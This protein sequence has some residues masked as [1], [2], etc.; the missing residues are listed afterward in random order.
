MIL[1]AA[2]LDAATATGP[3]R[4]LDAN[5]LVNTGSLMV[6]GT[7]GGTWSVDL[8]AS[9]DGINWSTQGTYTQASAGGLQNISPDTVRYLRANLTALSGGSS[10]TVTCVI[11]ARLTNT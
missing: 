2:S 11:A 5:G 4:T 8:E 6:T 3:G 7:G 9:L 1:P 10:P